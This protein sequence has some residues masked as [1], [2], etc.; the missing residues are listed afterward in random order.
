MERVKMNVSAVDRSQSIQVKPKND[1]LGV[2]VAQKS[3]E[4]AM[5]NQSKDRVSSSKNFS[6]PY[7]GHNV[8]IYV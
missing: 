4:A 1:T 7:L 3:L 8:D 5:Q 6:H 2:M